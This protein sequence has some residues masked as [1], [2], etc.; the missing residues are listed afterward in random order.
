MSR[1]VVVIGAGVIGVACGYYLQRDGWQVTLIDRGTVGGGASHGNCGYVSPSHVLPLAGPGMVWTGLKSLLQRNSPLKI[2]LRF[3]PGLW[4]W[5]A[6]FARRCNRRDMM[7]TARVLHA[8]LT[9]SR[10]L[11]DELF[12]TERLAAE[13]HTDGLL[14]VFRTPAAME[15]HAEVDALLREQFATPADR[16]DAGTLAAIEPSLRGDLAGAW[17]YRGD[18]YLRPD[19]LMRTWRQLLV[20]RGAVVHE[21]CEFIEFA[22]GA[23]RVSAVRTTIGEFECDAAIV[24]TGAW[25]PLLA[26]QL[27]MKVPIQPGKGYSITMDRPPVCPQLP[28]IFEEDRVAITPFANGL[29]LGSTMEFAGYDATMN[30]ARL[31]LLRD[32][33]APYFREPLTGVEREHWWGWRPMTPSGLPVVA[34]SPTY[35]NAVVAAG[36]GMLG[37]TLAPATGASVA[38][39]LQR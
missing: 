19:A 31:Q 25:T 13:W 33:A 17:H 2:R 9:E 5:L 15:H 39:M 4:G 30:P 38:A 32:G 16:I 34:F 20:D 26:R 28:M 37:V 24:A 1:R 8:M 6:G 23:E 18:A 11:Y 14:F 27:G 29:R 22:A 36:H 10:R 21:N 7:A 12:A 3:D 35:A